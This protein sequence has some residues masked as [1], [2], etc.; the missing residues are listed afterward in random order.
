MSS[1]WRGYLPKDLVISAEKFLLTSFGPEAE[2]LPSF[3]DIPVAQG[4]QEEFPSDHLPFVVHPAR[5]R[6]ENGCGLA[7][8][9]QFLF[10]EEGAAPCLGAGIED[11]L[12]V[13]LRV[14]RKSFPKNLCL[15]RASLSNED[16]F[17]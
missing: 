16:D 13:A 9:G 3:R 10:Q 4:F 8:R 6:V 2:I 12:H 17:S 15:K 14:G 7:I 11:D 1:S 5:P